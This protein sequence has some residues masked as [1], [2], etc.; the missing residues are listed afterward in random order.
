[1]KIEYA[2]DRSVAASR[3]R[4]SCSSAGAASRC[5]SAPVLVYTPDISDRGVAARRAPR[6]RCRASRAGRRRASSSDSCTRSSSGSTPVDR[7]RPFRVLD[8][9]R[10]LTMPAARDLVLEHGRKHPGLRQ[11]TS[12]GTPPAR[13]R[14]RRRRAVHEQAR[15][16]PGSRRAVRAHRL[17]SAPAPARSRRCHS[18]LMIHLP[19]SDLSVSPISTCLASLVTLGSANPASVAARAGDLDRLGQPRDP[20]PRRADSPQLRAARRS[21][22]SADPPTRA[23]GSDR[24]CAGSIAQRRSEPSSPRAANRSTVSCA[25]RDRAASSS[26]VAVRR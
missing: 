21:A 5:V 26:A 8:D 10:Q 1:M 12:A 13:P 4:R 22:P 24:S 3:S 23:R 17:R 25:A 18:Q 14:P 7:E 15:V 19:E 20:R 11:D 6:S 2:P 16:A 9:D